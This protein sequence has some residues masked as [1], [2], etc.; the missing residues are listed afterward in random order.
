M[1][2]F[3]KS[4]TFQ[5]GPRQL[6]DCLPSP[7]ETSPSSFFST[8][9][10]WLSRW[11]RFESKL[12]ICLKTL[13]GKDPAF[14]WLGE[15]NADGYT[16][17][18]LHI[19]VRLHLPNAGTILGFHGTLE[20]RHPWYRCES[21]DYFLCLHPCLVDSSFQDHSI[22]HFHEWTC[23]MILQQVSLASSVLSC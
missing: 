17:S 22:D 1:H 3:P 5:E 18:S 10:R 16:S 20:M 6:P 19:C 12:W 11:W 15:C 23:M 13:I 7:S 14:V 4:N 21:T 8:C 2:N 9:P